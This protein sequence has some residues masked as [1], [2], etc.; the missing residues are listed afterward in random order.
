MKMGISI[1]FRISIWSDHTIQPN[2]QIKKSLTLLA[3]FLLISDRISPISHWQTPRPGSENHW[4]FFMA[5][6]R[7]G[8]GSIIRAG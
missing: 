8:G 1:H 5:M 6:G 2:A 4:Q 3:I 7:I